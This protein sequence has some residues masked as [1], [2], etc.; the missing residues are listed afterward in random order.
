MFWQTAQLDEQFSYYLGVN[1]VES[2]GFL[3]NPLDEIMILRHWNGRLSFDFV[4]DDG[5]EIG[6][7]GTWEEFELGAQ[8]LVL[9]KFLKQFYN[10]NSDQIEN[11]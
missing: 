6:I 7:G 4:T 8:P 2:D 11:F 10:R 1:R 9:Q 5:L 3:N